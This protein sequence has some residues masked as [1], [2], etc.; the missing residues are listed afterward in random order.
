MHHIFKLRGSYSLASAFL[1]LLF[2]CCGN[3]F[4]QSGTSTVRGTV[5]DA[6]GNVV[7]GATVTL[8]NDEK[9]FSRTQTTNDQGGYTFSSVPPDVYRVEAEA[10][11]F[12]KT[13]VSDVRALVD[14]PTDVDIALEVGNVAETVDVSAATEAPLNTTDAT[15]GTAF[16]SRRIEDLPLNAR[17]VV[18]LLSLQP[19]VTRLGEVNGARRD[20]ANVTLDG[21]DVNEQQSGLDVVTGDAFAS[22]LRS[23]PD[24]VQEFRVTTSVP[25]AN[26]GRSSGAQVSLVTKSG[27][28][29]FRGSLYHWTHPQKAGHFAC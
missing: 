18:N 4:A 29:Q 2:C 23:T 28:N 12:K 19:G 26:Q 6:Q 22:V 15:I 11:S 7:A 14:T 1:F 24:S 20:Q 21:V 10:A 3:V 25:N 13:A 9:N 5:A 27:T 17:N 8:L 16:E